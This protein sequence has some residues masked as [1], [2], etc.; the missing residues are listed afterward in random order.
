MSNKYSAKAEK[1]KLIVRVAQ[2]SDIPAIVALSVKTY[3][4]EQASNEEMILGQLSNFPEGQFVAEYNG[5]VVGHC[6][7]FII[8]GEIALKP[9]T[10]QQITGLGYAA[11]H[12]PDG[13]YLYGMEV[14]VDE[15]YRRLRIGE[16]LYNA[17]KNLCREYGLKGIVFGGRMPNFA[18][19]L[20][21]FG[22]PEIYLEQVQAGNVKDPVVNFHLRSG[23]E[24]IG[25]LPNY[26]P[27]DTESLGYATHMLWRNPALDHDDHRPI[28]HRTITP[29][30]VRIASVQYQVRKV[31][32]FE[33]FA[34]QVE[35]FVD[36]ASGYRA[37]FVVF[38]ELFTIPLLSIDTERLSP[39]KSMERITEYTSDYVA[40]MQNLSVSYNINIIGG[41]HPTRIENGDIQN[42]AYVFLRDGQVHVQAKLHPTPN[43]SY[44]WNIKG[45]DSLKAIHTDCGP[46]G[47]LICYDSE[48]PEPARH[49]TDQGAKI[50]FVPFCTD[51]RQGYW[52]VRYCCQA[53]AIENQIYVVTAG[54]VGN[55]PDVENMDVHYAQ[56]G[57]FTPCD[58]PFAR[59]GIAALAEANTESVVVADLR[60]DQ[61]IISRNSGTVQNLKD[62]RFDLYH[63]AW[64]RT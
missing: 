17:R 56:S 12:D 51:E 33:D 32:S 40:L 30:S 55:L 41:S 36:V 42:H 19:R 11:R 48:F 54:I 45:G 4:L 47:V 46:I 8:A 53:R 26:L 9:H 49:L 52:R 60:L 24:V 13:D 29:K 5:E 59:D 22:S 10:W 6:A 62:R 20:K 37:D 64:K 2:H 39:Q 15:R 58:F 57:I 14:C 18:R 3:G 16:R 28:G 1:I 21:Q 23:F 27:G 44:W 61:L 35:Y 38:P 7:T 43:E 31:S 50:L 25:F 63:V 34:K